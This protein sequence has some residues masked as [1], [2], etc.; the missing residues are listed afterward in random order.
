MISVILKVDHA[1]RGSVPYG[2]G[3][4]AKWPIILKSRRIAA[5]SNASNCW[6]LVAAF[7]AADALVLVDFHDGVAGTLGPGLK[8]LALIGGVLTVGGDS[9]VDCNALRLRRHGLAPTVSFGLK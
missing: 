5:L 4:A 9:H 1:A 3:E 6:A 7:D 8:L 2:A